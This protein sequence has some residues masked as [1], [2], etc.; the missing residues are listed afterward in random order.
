MY[1]SYFVLGGEFDHQVVG[2]SYGLPQVEG[3]PSEEGS[4]GGWAVDDKE[5]N[6]FSDF[7]R[8]IT[9]HNGQRDCV[10]GVYFSSSEP[11]EGALVET[12]RSLSIIICWN[13]E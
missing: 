9:Y 10:E 2:R 7:L 11:D 4:I 1:F 6:V 13:A 5:R 3:R 8:I 12:S